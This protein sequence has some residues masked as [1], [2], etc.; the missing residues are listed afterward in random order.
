MGTLRK[1]RINGRNFFDRSSS[2]VAFPLSR[3]GLRE[4][5]QTQRQRNHQKAYSTHMG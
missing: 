5:T 3:S 2:R 1:F 4:C